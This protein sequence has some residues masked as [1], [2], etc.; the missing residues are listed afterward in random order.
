MCYYVVRPV[1]GKEGDSVDV[2]KH[3]K[4]STLAARQQLYY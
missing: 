2:P 1:V 4:Q 3:V